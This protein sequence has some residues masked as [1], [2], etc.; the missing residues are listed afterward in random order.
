MQKRFSILLPLA[1]LFLSL[2]ASKGLAQTA[3]AKVEAGA[4]LSYLNMAE[5]IGEGPG[6][7]GG[8]FSYNF[9]RYLALDADVSHYPQNP[10]GNFGQ[11][12]VSAGVKAGI[13]SERV[14]LF[15]KAKPGVIHFAGR[16]FRARHHG[17][18]DFFSF[19][20]GGVL[21]LYPNSRVLL[22]LDISDNIIDFGDE[23]FN[24]GFPVSERP[25]LSHNR[26]LSFGIGFR[27]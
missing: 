14:G 19:D 23:P 11:S 20:V 4:F 12:L 24:R 6:G 8:R 15:A 21:E 16:G 2:W 9:N 25:G 1:C 7:F 22:R 10:S 26:Q 17:S 5:S 18:R 27:F 13:R 3:V